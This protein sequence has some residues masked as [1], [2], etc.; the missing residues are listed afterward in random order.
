M[1]NIRVPEGKL[2]IVNIA[3]DY[4]WA[5]V[6]AKYNSLQEALGSCGLSEGNYDGYKTRWLREG[7]A[8]PQVDDLYGI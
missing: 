3:N 6:Y 8:L 2:W 5:T 4:S 1:E 7:E